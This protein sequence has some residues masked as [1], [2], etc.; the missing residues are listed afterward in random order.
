MRRLFD[1]ASVAAIL[2][3]PESHRAL[4]KVYGCSRETIR[5]IRMGRAYHDLLPDGY[6]PPP[7]SKDPNCERCKFWSGVDCGLG[8]PDPVEEGPWFAKDCSLF[9]KERC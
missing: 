4:G 6:T 2:A 8:F 5:L 1:A 9:E 7:S 3:S